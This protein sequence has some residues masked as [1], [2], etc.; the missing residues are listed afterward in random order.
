MRVL[1]T[2]TVSALVCVALT[3]T[4]SAKECVNTQSLDVKWTSYKTLEKIGVSGNF[5][6]VQ[7]SNKKNASNIKSLLVNTKVI[8]SLD[9]LDAGADVKNSAINKFFV[10]NL[11]SKTIT[12]NIISL[13]NDTLAVNI[14][15]NDIE[16]VI[17]MRYKI[18]N[19]KVQ[20]TGV[21]DALDF[22]LG[23]ALKVLNTSVAGHLNK[24][25]YDIPIS[26]DLTYNTKCM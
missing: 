24:G 19:G 5:N 6:D 17:P 22:G 21:I 15:L 16:K 4:L 2:M 12:A 18:A 20:A 10:N 25:W 8:L 13:S 7:Y 26:F 3:K 9:N 14:M 11:S 1:K 23:S